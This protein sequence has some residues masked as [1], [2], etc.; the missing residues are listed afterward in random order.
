M[1]GIANHEYKQSPY[2]KKHKNMLNIKFVDF[3]I[4]A[5]IDVA[6]DKIM[7]IAREKPVVAILIHSKTVAESFKEYFESL[8]KEAVK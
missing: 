8:W 2:Y 5:S 1:R 3:P 7:I 6:T 4:P